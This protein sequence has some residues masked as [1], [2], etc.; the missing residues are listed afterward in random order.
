MQF[1]L[2]KIHLLKLHQCLVTINGSRGNFYVNYNATSIVITFDY[3][4]GNTNEVTLPE[5]RCL[6]Q[7]AGAELL[8]Q[9]EDRR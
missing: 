8:M 5:I 1:K 6:H 2:I 3:V 9:M 7:Q 4:V